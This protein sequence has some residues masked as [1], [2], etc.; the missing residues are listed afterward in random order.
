M[1]NIDELI[2]ISIPLL[3]LLG[4]H[5]AVRLPIFERGYEGRHGTVWD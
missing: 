2:I 4:T 1:F 5:N 3:L